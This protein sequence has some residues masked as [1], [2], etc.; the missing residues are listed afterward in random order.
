MSDLPYKTSRD[1]FI[2]I[3]EALANAVRACLEDYQYD[4]AIKYAEKMR[5]TEKHI[6]GI[7]NIAELAPMTKLSVPYEYP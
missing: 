7:S 2:A 6:F 4:D 1:A 3:N 5:E